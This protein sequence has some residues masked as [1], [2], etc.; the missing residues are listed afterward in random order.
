MGYEQCKNAIELQ[1][2]Q[3]VAL[4]DLQVT[5]VAGALSGMVCLYLIFINNLIHTN[6]IFFSLL[7]PLRHHLMLQKQ[8]DK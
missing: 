4:T 3:Y 6:L 8:E 1:N 5:F 7:Q 2:K